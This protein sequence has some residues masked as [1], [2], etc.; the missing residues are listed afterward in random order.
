MASITSIQ[1]WPGTE[2]QDAATTP[3]SVIGLTN[4]PA[5]FAVFVVLALACLPVVIW[6]DL[7]NLSAETLTSQAQD[8]SVMINDIRAYYSSNVVGRVLAANGKATPTH[9]YQDVTGGIPIPAT[10]SLELGAVIGQRTKSVQYRFVSDYPFKGRASH[11][12]NE[13]ETK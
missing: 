7:R 12:L 4:H 9:K 10:L 1:E 6:L 2:Q 11:Q 3:K 5:L 8:V 13:F